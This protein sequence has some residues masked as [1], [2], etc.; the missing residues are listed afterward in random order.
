MQ[1][2]T[3]QQNIYQQRIN[4]VINYARENL[5]T[6]LS[7]ETL[8]RVANFSPLHFHRVF[9]ALTTETINEMVVRLRLERAAALLRATPHLSITEAAFDCGFTSVATFSRSFKKHFGLAASAWDRQC[10][11]KNSKIDQTSAAF[12]R[13]TMDML[14]EFAI[15]DAYQ[16]QVR[17]LPAQ[18]LAYIRVYD[19]YRDFG[20]ILAA[21]DQLWA[22]YYQQGDILPKPTSMG[23]RRMIQRSHRYRFAGSTGVLRCRWIGRQQASSIYKIFQP[24]RWP[25][26]V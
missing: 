13:Y 22:W 15:Q 18:R 11:L 4:T 16:V 21:H 19:A 24:A 6:D 5:D 2:D 3:I 1:T 7:L 10:S 26:C 8:A 17:S 12:P 23:C 9:K 20:R 14:A 25:Q